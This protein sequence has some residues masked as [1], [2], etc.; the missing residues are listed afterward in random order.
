MTPSTSG[1]YEQYCAA[2]VASTDTIYI[3]C[4]T[5]HIYRAVPQP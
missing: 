2:A 5:G 1:A 3:V 4:Y